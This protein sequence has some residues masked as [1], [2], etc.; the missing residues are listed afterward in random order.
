[1]LDEVTTWPGISTRRTSRGATA[2]VFDGHELG[3]VHRSRGTLDMPV[4]DDRRAEVLNPHG[5]R[6]GSEAGSASPSQ[7]TQTRKTGS[8]CCA[9]ATTSCTAGELV[10]PSDESPPGAHR[11]WAGRRQVAPP[12]CSFRLVNWIYAAVP[13]FV[14]TSHAKGRAS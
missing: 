3:H 12:R 9:K 14:V 6:T 5:R 10:Q 4:A 13:I 1:M 7:T 8:R 2:I 11:P